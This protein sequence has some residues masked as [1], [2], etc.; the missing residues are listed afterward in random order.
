M[1]AVRQYEQHTRTTRITPSRLRATGPGYFRFSSLVD[2][3][4]ATVGL[5]VTTFLR[6]VCPASPRRRRHGVIRTCCN[7]DCTG[8]VFRTRRTQNEALALGDPDFCSWRTCAAFITP[9]TQHVYEIAERVEPTAGSLVFECSS[10]MVTSLVFADEIALLGAV[11]EAERDIQQGRVIS[12][13]E[14]RSRIGQWTL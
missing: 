3:H 13:D 8:F 7:R 4:A 6:A 1:L 5:P 10:C 11:H 2:L 12:N 9:L 14:M